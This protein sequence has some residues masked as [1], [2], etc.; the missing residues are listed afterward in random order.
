MEKNKSY[1]KELTQMELRWCAI[2]CSSMDESV[3]KEDKEL[4]IDATLV[5][6]MTLSGMKVALSLMWWSDKVTV[7]DN[8]LDNI[9]TLHLHV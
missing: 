6:L 5:S 4:I 3:W 2:S 1:D 8:S 7:W 9:T